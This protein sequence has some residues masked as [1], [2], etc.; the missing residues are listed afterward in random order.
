MVD[1]NVLNWNWN[2]QAAAGKHVLSYVAGGITVAVG[3]HLLSPDQGTG[4]TDNLTLMWD[5]AVKFGEGAAGLASIALTVYNGLR[6]KNNASP[7]SQVKAVVANLA[8]SHA[9]QAANALD[10]PRSRNELI[11]AVAEMPEVRGIAAPQA[12]VAATASN[13]VV[14]TPE[15]IAKLP[16]AVPP[17]VTPITPKVA[18]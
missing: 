8:A 3:W 6:A 13:K 18:A 12:V 9:E 16:L 15:E 5:G 7:S 1:L 10:D 14:N 17:K 11:S 2:E 4:I